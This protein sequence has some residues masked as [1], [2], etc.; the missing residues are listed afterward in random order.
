MNVK[1]KAS[2]DNYFNVSNGVKQ[3]VLSPTLFA[4]YVDD[5]LQK[6]NKISGLGY[7][8]DIKL[9]G[10]VSYADD[11][12][13]LA[14]TVKALKICSLYAAEFDIKF[15]GAMSMDMVFKSRNCNVFNIDIYVN[16]DVLAKV[17]NISMTQVPH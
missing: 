6:L 14:P 13:M 2:T 4:V 17:N 12:F 7:Y 10:A 1:W 5:F 8:V 15:N 9:C 11:I 16:G 3:R